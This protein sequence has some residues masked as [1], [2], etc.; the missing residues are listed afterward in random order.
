MASALVGLVVV[1][2]I[3]M[4][5]VGGCRGALIAMQPTLVLNGVFL[6]GVEVVMMLVLVLADD[7]TRVVSTDETM[8][9]TQGGI[10]SK[11]TS[12][13]RTAVRRRSR[14]RA[15]FVLFAK[16]GSWSGHDGVR[17]RSVAGSRNFV[18]L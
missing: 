11:K 12:V 4:G 6:D 2:V 7:G 8:R 10:S 17:G 3:D 16:R 5:G 13:Y 15:A 1:L 9:N 14:Q 18:Q